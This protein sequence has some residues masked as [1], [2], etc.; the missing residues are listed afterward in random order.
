MG[1]ATR[2]YDE[3]ILSR[4]LVR[5]AIVLASV[6]WAGFL[7][8]QT[9]GDPGRGERIAA[10]VLA[11][12]AARAEVVAP[13]SASVMRTSGLPPDLRP[14]VDAEVD[15]VLRDPRGAQAFIDPFAGSWSRLLGEDD[16]R[17]PELDLAP[18]IDQFVG[19]AP[20]VVREDR[21][22]VPGVPLPRTQLDWMH[23]LR[24]TISAAI[25]PLALLSLGLFAVAFAI[26]DRGRVLRRLGAWAVLAGATWVV[27]PP[28]LVWVTRRWAPGADAVAAVA[29]D[30]AVSGLQAVALALVVGGVLAFGASFAVRPERETSRAPAAVDRRHRRTMSGPRRPPVRTTPDP[31]AATA[32]MPS[33]RQA[34]PTAEMPVVRPPA[35][36][37]APEADVGDV[38]DDGDALWDYYSSP[39]R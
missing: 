18:L 6:A 38:G 33:T 29:L 23:G 24:S 30:E 8:T 31:V 26:G 20:P 3:G 22:P 1:H 34:E 32:T 7:F 16:P 36:R 17:P 19:V 10:A 11:D 39:P 27:I 4:L 28:L 21:I 5:I 9:I 15:R 13:I 12:D 14:V 25:L 37:V 35:E 2:P